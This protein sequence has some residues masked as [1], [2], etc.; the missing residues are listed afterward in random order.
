MFIL[1]ESS[2]LS[3]SLS[4]FLLPAVEG[5]SRGIMK[6]FPS[7]RPFVMLFIYKDIFTEVTENVYGYENM[8]V[9]TFG[10]ILKTFENHFTLLDLD[11]VV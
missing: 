9:Q 5:R 10:L 3:H 2:L 11:S 7:V 6:C 1:Q 8:S 4:F